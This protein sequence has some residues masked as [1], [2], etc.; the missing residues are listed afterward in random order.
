MGKFTFLEAASAKNRQ[1]DILL[2]TKT[3]SQRAAKRLSVNIVTGDEK[4]AKEE[5]RRVEPVKP[6]APPEQ[7]G[8]FASRR[9]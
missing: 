8:I 7:R 9:I 5:R 4:Q 3:G 2:N 1:R 6:L